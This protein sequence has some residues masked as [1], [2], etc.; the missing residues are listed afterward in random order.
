MLEDVRGPDVGEVIVGGG[1]VG[2][3]VD[4]CAQGRLHG[5]GMD[6]PGE[7]V[8]GGE[9][10]DGVG[11]GGG[12]GLGGEERRVEGCA[13]VGGFWEREDPGGGVRAVGVPG[14]AVVEEGRVGEVG[15]VSQADRCC[16]KDSC[17]LRTP[18][19]FACANAHAVVG[20]IVC[21]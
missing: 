3:G 8:G 4:P 18:E 6:S 19:A 2:G 11:E 21:Y 15:E 10:L 14:C 12:E 5:V 13:V 20:A 7:E 16:R 1:G 9:E 17:W